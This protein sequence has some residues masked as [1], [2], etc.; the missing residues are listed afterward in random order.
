MR[1][2]PYVRAPHDCVCDAPDGDDVPSAGDP[3]QENRARPDFVP[4]RWPIRRRLSAAVRMR[5]N[6]VPEKRAVLELE[7]GERAVHDRRAGFARAFARELAL[8]RERDAAD[9]GAAIPSRLANEEELGAG[10]SLQIVDKP[11][12]AATRPL[13]VSVEVEGRADPCPS[14][15]GDER[16]PI[17]AA[18]R[19]PSGA[20]EPRS[21][22]PSR[23]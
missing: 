20:R 4:R 23:T 3:L 2:M 15:P 10:V 9:A 8:G 6:D 7:V 16:S 11:F 1:R 19:A 14:K 17:I 5:R 18:Q 13:A 21:A 22:R 12:T